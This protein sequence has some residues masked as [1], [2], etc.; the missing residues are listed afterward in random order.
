MVHRRR[1]LASC[2]GALAA[3]AMA[4]CADRLIQ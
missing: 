1:V 4:L 3:M 2:I